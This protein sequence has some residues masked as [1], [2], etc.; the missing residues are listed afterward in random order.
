MCQNWF[1]PGVESLENRLT[2]GLCSVQF[3]SNLL[4]INGSNLADNVTVSQPSPGRITLTGDPTTSFSFGGRIQSALTIGSLSNPVRSITAYMNTGNDGFQFDQSAPIM[5]AGNVVVDLGGGNDV[6]GQFGTQ[7]LKIAGSL[8]VR[9][10][11]G[12]AIVNL[13]DFSVTGSASIS[14]GSGAFESISFGTTFGPAN[15]KIGGTLTI[16]TATGDK[17]ITINTTDVTGGTSINGGSNTA[18]STNVNLIFDEIGMGPSLVNLKGGLVYTESPSNVGNDTIGLFDGTM[19]GGAV[20][21]TTFGPGAWIGFEGASVAGATTINELG[22]SGINLLALSANYHNS[23]FGGLVNI[24]MG[25]G[26]DSIAIDAD[27]TSTLTFLNAVTGKTGTG[28]DTVTI[29]GGG[30]NLIF[31]KG[32]TFD[33]G[34]GFDIWECTSDHIG[35]VLFI[36]FEFPA[37]PINA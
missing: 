35:I 11:T 20:R 36:N 22:A 32:A 9:H 3:F 21:I 31:N 30:T 16:N 25:N 19:V 10:G 23:T 37:P 2:P 7:P 1:R 6:L 8:T 33:G 13:A 18:G 26:A 24:T 28:N 5:L 12:N 14:L 27:A 15:N 29:A 4:V 34:P 17:E